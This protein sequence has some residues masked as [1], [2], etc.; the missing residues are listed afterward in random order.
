MKDDI[1]KALDRNRTEKS[2]I[3]LMLSLSQINASGSNLQLLEFEIAYD[4]NKEARAFL[5][6]RSTITIGGEEVRSTEKVR[7]IL[8]SGVHPSVC[9]LTFDSFDMLGILAIAKTSYVL[10]IWDGLVS[11][12]TEGFVIRSADMKWWT[13]VWTS[14]SDEHAYMVAWD[15]VRSSSSI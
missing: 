11:M 2:R 9:L 1:S 8:T 13:A 7:E 15:Y 3:A 6:A 12:D 4:L 10:S 5:D 14:D